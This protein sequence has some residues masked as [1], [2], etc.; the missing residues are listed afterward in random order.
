MSRPYG[1]MPRHRRKAPAAAAPAEVQINLTE[2]HTLEQL[3]LE[4]QR[5]VAILQDHGVAGVEK[6]R[7]R[8]LPLDEAAAPMALI[9]DKRQRVLTINIPEV[10]AEK[11]Y[12]TTSQ[13]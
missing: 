6:F 4:L 9:D 13:A 12:R 1:K 7:M 8:L 11:P 5:A 3:F 10:P 2:R